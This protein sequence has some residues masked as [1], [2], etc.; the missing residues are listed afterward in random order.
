M[1]DVSARRATGQRTAGARPCRK[2]GYLMMTFPKL[3][4]TFVSNEIRELAAQD[5]HPLLF[6]VYPPVDA[7]LHPEDEA[8]AAKTRYLE[9]NPTPMRERLH[10]HSHYL[11]RM[12][13][14]YLRMWI[15]LIR[16]LSP[17]YLVFAWRAMPWIRTLE[18]SEIAHLHC[19]FALNNSV[20]AW[21]LKRLAGVPYSITI[22]AVDIFC[23]LKLQR[24]LA[25]ANLL[26]IE[27]EYNRSFVRKF[28]P[29]INA[30]DMIRVYN[31]IKLDRFVRNTPYRKNDPFRIL[32]VGRLVEQKGFPY[33]VEALRIL[34]DRGIDGIECRIIGEGYQ[35]A[36]LEKAIAA[37]GLE[38]QVYL[39]GAQPTHVVRE[40]LERTN[41]YALP[42]VIPED[43][44]SD[45]LPVATK[46]AMAMG[47]P[48]VTTNTVGN[49]EIVD[50]TV[51]RL[52]SERDAVA[53]AD[54]I[55]DL[56]AMPEENLRRLGEAARERICVEHS[57][58]TEVAVLAKL[59]NE[60]IG[61][62]HGR[63]NGTR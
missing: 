23:N 45:S 19:H 32:G 41:L 49:P 43:G 26:V 17:Y 13:L 29:G 30:D 60:R 35:R 3:S 24:R 54:A 40:E 16:S 38:K 4:E 15:D 6:S 14:R 1:T 25:E 9:A 28:F 18:E 21:M 63:T 53:L 37:A 48:V 51:G 57:L 20:V 61:V 42:C 59:F 7:F 34:R 27:D 50:S 58:E 56:A 8:L 36:E 47:I 52:V 33:L 5:I 44:N 55:A 11:R 10:A 31:G 12:P 39:L 62:C 2:L 46:E 22:H